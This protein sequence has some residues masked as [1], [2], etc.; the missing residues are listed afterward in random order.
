MV[1]SVALNFPSPTDIP[2]HI[3]VMLWLSD[4]TSG[5]DIALANADLVASLPAGDS[6]MTSGGAGTMYAELMALYG[7]RNPGTFEVLNFDP[8]QDNVFNYDFSAHN[9]TLDAIASVPEPA[10]LGLLALA[11]LGLLARRRR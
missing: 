4:T 6:L 2:S 10:S 8:L 9:V 7:V 11:G 5:A 1:G 3:F